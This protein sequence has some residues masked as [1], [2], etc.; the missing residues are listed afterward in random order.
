LKEFASTL[1]CFDS[2]DPEERVGYR[3]VARAL[4]VKVERLEIVVF[5]LAS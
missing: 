4:R 3:A 1:E 2:D 5:D